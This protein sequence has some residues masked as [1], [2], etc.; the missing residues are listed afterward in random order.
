[1][2]EPV[3][4]GNQTFIQTSEGWV[5]SKTK[6]KAPDGLLV[7]LNTLTKE[8]S[9]EE[10]KKRV[11]I[12]PSRPVV[13]L[14]KTEY[15]WDL[16]NGAWI[17]RKTRTPV[18][19][20]F[21]SL[22][23]STYQKTNQEVAPVA[24]TSAAQSV[25]GSTGIVGQAAQTKTPTR[26]GS[27]QLPAM[28][29][30]KINTPLVQMIDQLVLL[31]GY[32]NQN[33]KNQ[34]IKERNKKLAE[35][36][37]T[38]EAQDLGSQPVG[39]DAVSVSKPGLGLGLLAAGAVL[40][41]QDEIVE[42]VT[43]IIEGVKSLGSFIGDVVSTINRAFDFLFGGDPSVNNAPADSTNPNIPAPAVSNEQP[44]P[45]ATP[46]TPT[47]VSPPTEGPGFLSTVA[48]GA[49]V[50][51]VVSK[52]LPFVKARTGI[53]AGAGLAAYNY[54]TS[55]SSS[56]TPAPATG[57]SVATGGA[58]SSPTP[59][60]SVS[61]EKTEDATPSGDV[62][63][64]THP[65]TGSGWTVKGALDAN[66]RPIVFSKEGA[67]AFAKMMKDSGGV[68]KPSD[69]H[70]SKRSIAKN[71]AVDG[72]KNSPHLRGVA[73]DIHGASS[74]WIRANGSKYGWK[75]HDYSGTHG[76][77]FVFGGQGLSPDGSES[78]VSGGGD[79]SRSVVMGTLKDLGKSIG[80]LA[81]I[82]VGPGTLRN[83]NS[84]LQDTGAQISEAQIS[85]NATIAAAKTEVEQ[86]IPVPSPPNIN[87]ADSASVENPPTMS[88]RTGV[89]Y[90]L[91]RFGYQELSTPKTTWA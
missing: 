12:D 11:R 76:G 26:S 52:A 6:I 75:P 63:Q 66:G 79:A 73:M 16:N 1:M 65:E 13:K 55:G 21:S 27:G 86:E 46:E 9:T 17:D 57:R 40:A 81:A 24:G 91:R 45:D 48:G 87:V 25:I 5:D 82:L 8:S 71:T 37:A 60:G 59:S 10:K 90:Y 54:M 70:S 78:M 58:T 62:V 29:I 64:V 67:E 44:V 39:R 47:P 22:I 3:K 85:K 72:A 34:I 32:L 43:P 23:E 42:V 36:E 51:G 77:H 38:I 50:G 14:G 35:R 31:E 28:P 53:I 61:S 69:V 41:F 7:L 88:D 30:Q 20:R 19:P 18:N 84:A 15:V 68:V 80:E 4:I 74:A 83:I 33:L 49:I 56:S 2:A 89:F